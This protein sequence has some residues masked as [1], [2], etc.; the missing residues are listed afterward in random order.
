MLFNPQSF[1]T[2]IK[3][4]GRKAELNKLYIVTEFQKSA[5]EDIKT[6][7]KDGAYCYGFLLEGARWDIS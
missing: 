6:E 1:L 7:A 4:V 3:Q 5:I 2:A